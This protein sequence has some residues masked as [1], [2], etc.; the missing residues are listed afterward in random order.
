M[1]EAEHY[2]CLD[3]GRNV[4]LHWRCEF[5]ATNTDGEKSIQEINGIYLTVQV[6]TKI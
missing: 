2:L 1:I 6:Q 4:N 3:Q 5:I